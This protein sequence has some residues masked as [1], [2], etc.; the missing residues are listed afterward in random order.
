MKIKE[1]LIDD[2]FLIE[3][4]VHA[5]DRGFFLETYQKQRYFDYANIQYEFV[6]DNHSS[7]SC[8]VLRGLHFQKKNPQGKL[9]RCIHGNIFDVAVDLRPDSQTFKQWFGVNLSSSNYLQLW[10]PPGLA[11]GF[12]VTSNYAEVEYKCTEY[13]DPKSEESLLWNDPDIAIKWPNVKPIL[14]AKDK[15]G[16]LFSELF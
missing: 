10:V 13:Y 1:T 5:D 3:P 9:V 8:G 15:E 2:C 14:S 6:Q 7:S 12:L 16:K 11:H 4:M